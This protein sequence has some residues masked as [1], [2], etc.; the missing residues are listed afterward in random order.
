MGVED[1]P[2]LVEIAPTGG[3]PSRLGVAKLAR[4]RVFD[5]AGTKRLSKPIF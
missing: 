4:V 5:P 3:L 1:A 2:E